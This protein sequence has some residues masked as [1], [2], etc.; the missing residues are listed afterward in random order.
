METEEFLQ[1]YYQDLE[2]EL[3]RSFPRIK[4]GGIRHDS[5]VVRIEPSKDRDADRAELQ[6]A[7]DWIKTVFIPSRKG[8]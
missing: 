6:R 7:L 8:D 5:W 2:N 4:L 3:K 1:T